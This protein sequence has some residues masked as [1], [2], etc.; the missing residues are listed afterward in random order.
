MTVVTNIIIIGI[1]SSI[2][3]LDELNYS[4]VC[5]VVTA[6]TGFILLFK[7]S[8][9]FNLSR[10]ILFVGVVTI[11]TLGISLFRDLFSIRLDASNIV[12]II[13]LGLTSIFVGV[14][15][16]FIANRIFKVIE[17]RLQDD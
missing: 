7:I 10:G 15:Y 8:R 3:N 9:P 1:I 4:S 6:I 5:V 11:F 16:N 2:Y 12:P 13:I 14:L 17:K